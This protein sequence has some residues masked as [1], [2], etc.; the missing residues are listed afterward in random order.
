M[1]RS[2]SFNVCRS[3]LKGVVIGVKLRE[4]S[5]SE[6]EGIFNGDDALVKGNLVHQRA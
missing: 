5:K 6:F 4:S 2:V 1:N 3:R